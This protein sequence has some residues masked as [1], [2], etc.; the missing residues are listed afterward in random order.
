MSKEPFDSNLFVGRQQLLN[1]I[2]TW[3]NDP[4]PTHRLWTITA[5][6]GMGKSWLLNAVKYRLEQHPRQLIFW[7]DLNRATS[8]EASY[9]WTNADDRLHWLDNAITRSRPICNCV[10]E[11]NPDFNFDAMLEALVRC[12]CSDPCRHQMP[13][14]L[15]IVDGFEDL[16]DPNLQ[17]FLEEHLFSCYHGVT[18]TRI[19]IALRDNYSLKHPSLRR[20]ETQIPLGPLN[21]AVN[22]HEGQAQVIL[23]DEISS[24]PLKDVSQLLTTVPPYNWNHPQINSELYRRCCLNGAKSNDLLLTCEDLIACL[25]EIAKP[26]TLGQTTLNRLVALAHLK[27]SQPDEFLDIWTDYDMFLQLGIRAADP[28]IEQLFRIG[29]ITPIPKGPTRK[30]ADGVRELIRAWKICREEATRGV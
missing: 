11:F 7:V 3:I 24:H 14:P 12:L 1:R 16:T 23:R 8:G 18:C 28:D 20:D 25:E 9:D 17:R 29:F 5:S 10:P 30:I 26:V 27:A 15:M 19:I 2:A 4:N 21:T 22:N 6:S 13:A